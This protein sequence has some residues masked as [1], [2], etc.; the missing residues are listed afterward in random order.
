MAWYSL[1]MDGEWLGKYSCLKSANSY[2]I[3]PINETLHTCA[4]RSPAGWNYLNAC[5]HA[6]W[7]A[8]WPRD[9]FL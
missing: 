7:L 6:G 5:I 1:R 3:L 4:L 8:G 2:D 9:P